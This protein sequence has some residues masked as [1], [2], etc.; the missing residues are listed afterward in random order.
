[1]L[2]INVSIL[3]SNGVEYYQYISDFASIFKDDAI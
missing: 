2:H 1:M 3:K